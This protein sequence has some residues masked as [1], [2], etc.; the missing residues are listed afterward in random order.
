MLYACVRNEG[1]K[2]AGD[3]CGHLRGVLGSHP[4]HGPADSLPCAGGALLGRFQT[5]QGHLPPHGLLQQVSLSPV[6]QLSTYI[7]IESHSLT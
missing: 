7:R 5:R 1:D 6:S 2:D 4:R 3:D